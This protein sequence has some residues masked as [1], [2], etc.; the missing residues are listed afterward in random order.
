MMKK[1]RNLQIKD[2]IQKN[3]NQKEKKV[4]RN[5][6]LKIRKLDQKNQILVMRK[7]LKEAAVIVRAI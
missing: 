3:Q 5:R 7:N 4:F 1:G 6:I 2:L